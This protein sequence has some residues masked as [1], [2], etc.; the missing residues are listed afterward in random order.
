MD[1]SWN[2]T[3]SPLLPSLLLPPLPPVSE[4]DVTSTGVGM[5]VEPQMILN[6]ST[7]KQ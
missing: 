5:L 6:A 3:I 2:D 1:V 7:W 4:C